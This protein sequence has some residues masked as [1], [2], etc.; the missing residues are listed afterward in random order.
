[1]EGGLRLPPDLDL[2]QTVAALVC[3]VAAL[4]TAVMQHEPQLARLRAELKELR[5]SERDHN[6]TAMDKLDTESILLLASLTAG[7]TRLD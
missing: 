2:D 3:S 4:K 5:G 7:W 1:M 6:T